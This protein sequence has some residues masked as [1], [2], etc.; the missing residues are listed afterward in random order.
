[1]SVS[2]EQ[3]VYQGLIANAAFTALLAVD[4]GNNVA[5]YDKQLPQQNFPASGGSGVIYP[6]GVYQRISSPRLFAHG[7]GSDPGG[8]ANTGLARFQFTFWSNAS[9][10][11]VV[12]DQIDRAVKGFFQTFT[13]MYAP[14]S[15]P[16]TN[17]SFISYDSRTG[18]E[19]DTQP[20]LQKLIIDVRFWFSD[21]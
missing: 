2:L 5:F 16:L 7:A 15:P 3:L 21:Q 8:Q 19:P 10:G 17:P 6:A 13:A 4:A 18:I 1:M 14:G 11:T 20:V 9:N 12:L